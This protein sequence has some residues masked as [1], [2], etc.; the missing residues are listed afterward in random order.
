[1]STEIAIEMLRP[2]PASGTVYTTAT[3]VHADGLGGVATGRVT[4]QDGI[5]L[6]SCSQRGRFIA[7]PPDLVEEGS[8]GA[9]LGVGDLDRLLATRSEEPMR[10]TDVLS[11]EGGSL[12]GGISMFASD[13]VAGAVAPGL[14][15]ASIHITYTRAVA[16]G[17]G[18]TWRPDVRHLGRSLAVVDV[19]GVVDGRVC[20]TA[21]VVLQPPS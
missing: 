7:A 8:W 15:T 3:L 4:D 5:V 6:A 10:A 21:R 16:I 14:V 20:T 1:V 19:D 9:P 2:L 18:V 11:N 13:L 17:A 12:H